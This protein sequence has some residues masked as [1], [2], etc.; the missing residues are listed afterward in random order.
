MSST[1][2]VEAARIPDRDQLA[3]SSCASTASTAEPS[4]ELGDRGAVRRRRAETASD[5]RATSRASIMQHRRPIVPIKHEGV[6]YI[7][8]PVG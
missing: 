6:I 4:D 7:R 5:L 3:R 1:I 2:D 8:P